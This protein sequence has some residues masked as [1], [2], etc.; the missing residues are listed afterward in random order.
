MCVGVFR[1]ARGPAYSWIC[2]KIVKS[3]QFKENN[4]ICV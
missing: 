1:K 3:W 4:K 2:E